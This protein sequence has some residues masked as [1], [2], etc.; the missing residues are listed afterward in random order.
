[1]RKNFITNIS[2]LFAEP[3]GETFSGSLG[4]TGRCKMP[5]GPMR[6]YFSLFNFSFFSGWFYF[7]LFNFRIFI[8]RSLAVADLSDHFIYCSI[9]HPVLISQLPYWS[10]GADADS[11]HF[12]NGKAPCICLKLIWCYRCS[13]RWSHRWSAIILWTQWWRVSISVQL[14][15]VQI[16]GY[17]AALDR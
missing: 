6:V 12:P 11:T 4:S 13:T 5:W 1:M 15:V 2:F 17:I 14:F 10:V 8:F 7:S 3:V 16:A 9:W